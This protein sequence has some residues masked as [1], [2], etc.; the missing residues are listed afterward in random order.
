MYINEPISYDGN[1]ATWIGSECNAFES[2]TKDGMV[3]EYECG[4]QAIRNGVMKVVRLKP[5]HSIEESLVRGNGRC[6]I[7]LAFEPA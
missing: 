5:I 3:S 7:S 6:V 4:C 1:R 2:I